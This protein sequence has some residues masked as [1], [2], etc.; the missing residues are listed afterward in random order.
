MLRLTV[1]MFSV[2]LVAGCT[3]VQ[4][5]A[6]MGKEFGGTL[7]TP[8]QQG[9]FKVGN[10]YKIEGRTYVP[11]EQ[12]D[13]VETGIASWYGPGF[14]G[15]RTANG[16]KFDKQEL[17]AAHRTLQMPSLVRVTNLD[18]GRSVIVRVNDRGPFKRGRIIDVSE[19]AADLLGF[20]GHGTAKVK[21]EV[22]KQESLQ[23][24][25]AARGGMDTRGYELA[26][27]DAGAAAR[28]TYQ[29]AAYDPVQDPGYNAGYSEPVSRQVLTAPSDSGGPIQTALPGHLKE[30]EFYPDPVVMERPVTPTN[31][32]VQAGAFS[33]YD[34]AVKLQQ[35]LGAF[36]KA[37]VTPIEGRGQTLYR[38]RLGPVRTV[39][40]A[41]ALLNRV[42]NSGHKDA[43]IVVE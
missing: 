43:I 2:L 20:K 14:H 26:T 9:T 29:E 37:S 8:T 12:Y 21:L 41:D 11:R 27:N 5:A 25:Q 7:G 34:N 24:A 38:V 40:D 6:E 33:V 36:D 10:P 42:V 39:E 35:R 30:G 1:L 16:E 28:P 18:N 4:Y 3:E 32:F 15:K 23:I 22:L 17:T 31:I 19:K 13:L